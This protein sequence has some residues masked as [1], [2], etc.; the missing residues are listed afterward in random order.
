[1]RRTSCAQP[2]GSSASD[3]N[4]DVMADSFAGMAKGLDFA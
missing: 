3:R 1:V 4:T 2:S